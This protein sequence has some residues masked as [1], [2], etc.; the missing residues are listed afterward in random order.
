MSSAPNR[1][2]RCVYEEARYHAR[3]SIALAFI[4][5]LQHLPARQRAV[6][7]LRDVLGFPTGEVADMLDT[8]E[9]WVTAALQHARTTIDDLMPGPP[10]PSPREREVVARFAE[11]FEAGDERFKL[12]PTRANMQPAFAVYRREPGTRLLHADGLMVLTLDGDHVATVARFPDTSFF[13]RFG[14]PQT[15]RE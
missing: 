12:I 13:E 3:E 7:V 6:L 2:L 10:S 8:S 4:V 9:T 5:A 14:L 11:D 15:L 1:G